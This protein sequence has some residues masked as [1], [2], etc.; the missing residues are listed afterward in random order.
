MSAEDKLSNKIDD[1]GGKAKEAA[2][3]LTGDD[4]TENEGVGPGRRPV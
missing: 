3:R 1:M 4:G 2:G